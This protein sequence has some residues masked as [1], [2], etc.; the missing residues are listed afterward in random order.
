MGV[1][2]LTLFFG[3][4]PVAAASSKA[5]T[6]ALV[7]LTGKAV[8]AGKIFTAGSSPV[9]LIDKS[10]TKIELA[11]FSVTEFD[12]TGHMKLLRG[13]ALM[14]SRAERS[15]RTSSAEIDFTGR[16]LVSYDHKDRSTSTFVLDGEARMVNPHQNDRSLR[17]ERFRGAT[18][19]VGGVVPQLIR[20]L[21][22]ASVEGWMKGYAWPEERSREILKSLPK[23]MNV[24]KEPAARHLEGT[25]LEDYFS[26]IETANEHEQ[27]DYY[28]RKFLDPDVAVAEANSKKEGKT[29]SPEEAALIS[30][31]NTRI[32]LGFEIIGSEQ[33]AKEVA[34]SRR[35]I[36]APASTSLPSDVLRDPAQQKGA[37]PRMGGKKQRSTD[38]LDPEVNEVLERL[39][40][41]EA[42]PPVISK[43][44]S[45]PSDRRPASSA[46]G[47]VPDPVYDYSE[48]F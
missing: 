41:I 35:G 5:P 13:S 19:E 40:S 2:F 31:P 1:M 18:L 44:P 45:L 6:V 17:L 30:L 11:P 21:D 23:V 29:M 33:K 47:I 8:E 4:A 37:A 24:A 46:P 42:K 36:R 38:G 10:N 14:E 20:Q 15:L 26:S 3:I 16:V 43:V 28:D 22:F 25:K 7:A 9:I 12:D 32:D 27:P 34:A 39:R 48:N